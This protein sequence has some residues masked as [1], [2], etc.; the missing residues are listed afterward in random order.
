LILVTDRKSEAAA[1][2][3]MKAGAKDY[4]ITE[5]PARFLPI[6]ER[7]LSDIHASRDGKR[8]ERVYAA[9]YKISESA[10]SAESLHELIQSIH[11]IVGELMPANNFYISLYDKTADLITFPYYVDEN[12]NPPAPNRPGK[13]LTEY[14]LRTGKPLLAPEDVFKQLEAAGEVESIGSPSV[15]WLGVPLKAEEEII[16]VLVV[17]SYTEGS[18]FAK[19]T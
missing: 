14:V 16:G 6:I 7:E 2:Q 12:D 1:I 5:H 11:A 10:S 19:R 8:A 4:V 3:A 17:Q 13:G 9:T 15:D 18:I